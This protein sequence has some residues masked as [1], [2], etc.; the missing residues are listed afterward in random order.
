M[1]TALSFENAWVISTQALC[2]LRSEAHVAQYVVQTY[3]GCELCQNKTLLPPWLL[4]TRSERARG[5]RGGK[6]IPM[7]WKSQT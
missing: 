2:N 1:C 4:F 7:M 6:E 5:G 3:A